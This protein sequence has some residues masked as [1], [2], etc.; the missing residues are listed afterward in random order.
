MPAGT[1]Q[2]CECTNERPCEGGCAWV[3]PE[4]NL[5]DRCAVGVKLGELIGKVSLKL[6]LPRVVQW[7]DRPSEDQQL[8]VKSGRT[9]FETMV[10]QQAAEPRLVAEEMGDLMQALGERFPAAVE[11]AQRAGRTMTDLVLS[12]INEPKRVLLVG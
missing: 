12:L 6:I 1:C 11:D 4:L 3:G 8:L 9:L 7:D 5:C 2:Y 10:T